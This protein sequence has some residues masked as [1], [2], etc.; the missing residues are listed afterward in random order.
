M[1]LTSDHCSL[2]VCC[3]MYVVDF[4]IFILCVI[5]LKKQPLAK[6]NI[7]LSEVSHTFEFHILIRKDCVLTILLTPSLTLISILNIVLKRLYDLRFLHCSRMPGIFF[8]VFDTIYNN[9]T[10]FSCVEVC[11]ILLFC[12]H[13]ASISI[14][15]RLYISHLIRCIINLSSFFYKL[16]KVQIL[17]VS[18]MSNSF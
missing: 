4:L 3:F 15:F 2:I 14:V 16:L 13:S 9:C 18:S 10:D 1:R 12:T 8:Y 6:S 17:F 5:I 7:S 11:K